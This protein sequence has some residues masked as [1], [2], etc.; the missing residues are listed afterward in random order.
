[1]KIL[2]KEYCKFY[3]IDVSIIS[4]GS[5]PAIQ[6]KFDDG[7]KIIKDSSDQLG[8]ILDKEIVSHYIQKRKKK[9][10]KIKNNL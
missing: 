9:I 3:N 5:Y 2:D 10:L 7:Y 4:N 6:I 1:M 8:D